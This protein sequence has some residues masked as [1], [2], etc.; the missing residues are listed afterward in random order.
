MKNLI[1]FIALLMVFCC[2]LSACDYVSSENLKSPNEDCVMVYTISDTE[3]IRILWQASSEFC[4]YG[5]WVNGDSVRPVY[6]RVELIG[7]YEAVIEEFNPDEK[8]HTHNLTCKH[9]LFKLDKGIANSSCFIEP[10]TEEKIPFTFSTESDLNF[11][12]SWVSDTLISFKNTKGKIYEEQELNFW[13]DF[14][15]SKG[16]WKVNEKI[17]PIRMEIKAVTPHSVNLVVY[18]ISSE[19]EQKILSVWGELTDEN[20]LI[21]DMLSDHYYRFT[22]EMFYEDTV[23]QIVISRVDK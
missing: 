23:S 19:Q 16:E 1:C 11:N 14:E 6:L 18:D 5:E 12:F 17:I 7:G 22:N 15:N 4:N 20:T 21:V 2:A 3:Y 8:N 10:E 9:T 13:Y